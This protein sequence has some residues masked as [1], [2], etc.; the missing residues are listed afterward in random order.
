MSSSPDEKSGADPLEPVLRNVE[1]ELRS[2][3]REA[4]E[5]EASGL[6]TE[7][8]V[9][10]RRLE[11]SLLAAAVAAEQTISLRRH[12]D[13]RKREKTAAAEMERTRHAYGETNAASEVVPKV[14]EFRDAE[15]QL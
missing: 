15:G 4:C 12:M 14:R 8:A 2:R 11:D 6:S 10:I 1:A 3:L 5:A 13:Q 9:E 7:S